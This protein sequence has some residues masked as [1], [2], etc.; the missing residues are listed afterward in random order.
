[1]KQKD[2]EKQYNEMISPPHHENRDENRDEIRKQLT[3]TDF[4][5]LSAIYEITNLNM[6]IAG[7]LQG[8]YV[9]NTQNKPVCNNLYYFSNNP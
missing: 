7:G 5:S 1:M 4:V 8:N 3:V 6:L 9:N 2:I